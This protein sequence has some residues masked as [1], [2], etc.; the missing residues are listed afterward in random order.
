MPLESMTPRYRDEAPTFRRPPQDG[1]NAL[2]LAP[3][4]GAPV[5]SVPIAEIPYQSRITHREEMLP[6]VLAIMSPPGTDLALMDEVLKVMKRSDMP[7]I[8]KTGRSMFK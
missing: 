4:L 5:L 6:L 7:T 1:I 2:A 8:V 3:V